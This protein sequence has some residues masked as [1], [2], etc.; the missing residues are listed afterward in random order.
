[1]KRPASQFEDLCFRLC[2]GLRADQYNSVG[3]DTE[4]P[5]DFWIQP[6]GYLKQIKINVEIP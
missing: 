3:V 4:I 5:G 6:L 2:T 1:M